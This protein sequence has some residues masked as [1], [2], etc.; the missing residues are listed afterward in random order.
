MSSAHRTV[1]LRTRSAWPTWTGSKLSSRRRALGGSPCSL[2]RATLV[3]PQMLGRALVVGSPGSGPRDRRGLPALA[4]QR[5]GLSV[6]KRPGVAR[7]VD[8][9][10]GMRKP[11]PPL[12][13]LWGEVGCR[14]THVCRPL[15]FFQVGS[16]VVPSRRCL[17]VPEFWC[18]S[19]GRV[20]LQFDIPGVSRRLGAGNQLS[21][22]PSAAPLSSLCMAA[23]A[24]RCSTSV[25]HPPLQLMMV[26]PSVRSSTV[27]SPSRWRGPRAHRRRLVV[28][29]PSSTTSVSTPARRRLAGSTRFS[30]R[31]PTCSTTLPR[32]VHWFSFGPG[33]CSD[34]RHAPLSC[35]MLHASHGQHRL[36]G[37]ICHFSLSALPKLPLTCLPLSIVAS[38]GSNE[39][40]PGCGPMG[41]EAT[42]GWDP[43]TGLGVSVCGLSVWTGPRICVRVRV[44]VRACVFRVPVCRLNLRILP[45]HHLVAKLCQDEGGCDGPAVR[46]TTRCTLAVVWTHHRLCCED[47]RPCQYTDS[48]P[49]LLCSPDFCTTVH[50]RCACLRGRCW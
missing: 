7:L 2:P 1:S 40:G 10:I 30:T 6:G 25:V 22:K 4:A 33:V 23:A 43:V 13:L 31:T 38:Q 3:S 49:L 34:M 12:K 18:P 37:S 8:S 20:T 29:F 24:P 35:L 17:Q 44:R 27:D 11:A 46:T 19:S 45:V 47:R 41:F 5:V 26:R 48:R 14:M 16:P 32:C 21:G 50:V 28:F 42:K 39:A 36:S 15:S 9:P